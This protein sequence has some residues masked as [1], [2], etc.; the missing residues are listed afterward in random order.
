[1]HLEWSE[2]DENQKKL[3]IN[4]MNKYDR[5]ILKM[6]SYYDRDYTMAKMG[7]TEQIMAVDPEYPEYACEEN[8]HIQALEKYEKIQNYVN[9][10]NSYSNYNF[11]DLKAHDN[12]ENLK[13][14]ENLDSPSGP[15]ST[16]VEENL[17]SKNKNNFM[18]NYSHSNFVKFNVSRNKCLKEDLACHPFISK[19]NNTNTFL[20]KNKIFKTFSEIDSMDNNYTFT[21]ET[22]SS[23]GCDKS[24][25]YD[26]ILT[27]SMNC[28]DENLDHSPMKLIKNFN[29]V[30]LP[31]KLFDGL[32]DIL[33]SSRSF[34]EKL[35]PSKY[36]SNLSNLYDLFPLLFNN[37]SSCINKQMI[38]SFRGECL[39]GI[40][41]LSKMDKNLKQFY[42]NHNDNIKILYEESRNK[43][44][45]YVLSVIN[46]N[47]EF[48]KM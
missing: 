28:S 8:Q 29:R 5:N 47:K 10:I 9:I 37:I 13:N 43:Q 26:P 34:Q 19:L 17:F 35:F 31:Q 6:F 25:I 1:V 3:D 24:K 22:L 33:N 11:E 2:K 41:Y 21:N 16:T 12:L 4:K 32:T 30:P 45:N 20:H 39:N 23:Q 44:R 48:N 14:S 7:S 40:Y 18:Q 42:V 36:D 46:K 38:N 15:T 27:G